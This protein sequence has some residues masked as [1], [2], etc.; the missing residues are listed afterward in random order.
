M[1]MNHIMRRFIYVS[2]FAFTVFFCASMRGSAQ[3]TVVTASGQITFYGVGWSGNVVR[4]QTTAPFVANG[5]AATDGYMTDATDPGNPAYQQALHG[6]FLSGRSVQLVL[7]GCTGTG[8]PKII[9]VNVF[10]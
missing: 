5:C 8:R 2:V 3:A 4:V 7:S 6:A 10:R 1:M 9:G